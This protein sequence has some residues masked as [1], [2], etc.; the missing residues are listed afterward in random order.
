MI[1]IPYIVRIYKEICA[2]N[3]VEG[4][5]LDVAWSLLVL[6]AIIAILKRFTWRWK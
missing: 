4:Y 3:P 6:L 5:L 2:E 1:V